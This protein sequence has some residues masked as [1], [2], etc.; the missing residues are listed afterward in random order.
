MQRRGALRTHGRVGSLLYSAA[1]ARRLSPSAG[2]GLLFLWGIAPAAFG[3]AVHWIQP[4]ATRPIAPRGGILMLPLGA[5]RPGDNWPG[6]IPLTFADG[7]SV[8][9]TIA[10]IHPRVDDPTEPRR[11]TDDVAGLAVRPIAPGDDSGAGAGAP[12]LLARLPV[13]GE[14]PIELGRPARGRLRPLWRNVDRS[15]GETET[16]EAPSARLELIGSPDRPDPI[17]PF[18]YWRWVLLAERLHARPPSTEAYG[19]VGGLVAEHYADIWR[20]G[21]DRLAALSEGVA[22]ACRDRLTRICTDPSPG[23]G[24]FAAW[25]MR[26]DEVDRLL[27]LL[28]DPRQPDADLIDEALAWANSQPSLLIWREAASEREVRLSIVNRDFEPIVA[29]L[30]WQDSG[31]I[32]L[33][34]EL[35]PGRLTQVRLAR[36]PLAE[37]GRGGI[38]TTEA[39]PQTDLRLETDEGVVRLAFPRRVTRA[40]PPGAFFPPMRPVLTLAAIE[41]GRQQGIDPSRATFMHVRRLWDRWEVFFECRRASAGAADQPGMSDPLGAF[42]SPFEARGVEA[43]TLLI[44]RQ[45]SP[46]VVLTVPETG[47]HRLFAGSNDGTLQVHRRSFSDRWYC[48]IVLPEAWLPVLKDI[49][50]VLIGGAR[51]H[52]DGRAMETTPATGPPWRQRPGR[53][54]LILGAWDDRLPKSLE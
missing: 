30:V 33:A 27:G 15:V 26:R 28:L 6:A 54:A 51:T 31:D 53:A 10:W 38:G 29:R 19:P 25:V 9:G 22:A 36:P 48:R 11:W 20:I 23:G 32:P 49:S 14:G 24:D 18:E 16:P 52:G 5:P 50:P 40:T 46:D 39:P 47:W 35:G 17:S 13:D 8:D 4:Q 21:L 43:V 37:S 2:L 1:S 42:A 7:S 41:S 45:G 34:V 44:G 3:D 12:Y